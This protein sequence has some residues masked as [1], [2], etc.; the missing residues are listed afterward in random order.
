MGMGVGN[1]VGGTGAG[2]RG[3]KLAAGGDGGIPVGAM[4]DGNVAGTGE[5]PIP[6]GT[7]VRAAVGT[8]GCGAE[9]RAGA[10]CGGGVRIAGTAPN[11]AEGRN[12]GGARLG[13]AGMAAWDTEERADGAE[14]GGGVRTGIG[15]A[16]TAGWEAEGRT[17][18][19]AE[20][21]TGVRV[22]RLVTAGWDEEARTGGGAAGLAPT[23][24]KGSTGGGVAA[25][26]ER[27]GS[28]V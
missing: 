25:P 20:C 28:G 18:A 15:T 23:G 16:V 21:G 10:A 11:E 24:G 22:G 19:V 3:P 4:G 17:V 6:G 2:A 5:T 8:A 9:I 27:M 7:E 1:G 13:S 26:S 14:N 12:A